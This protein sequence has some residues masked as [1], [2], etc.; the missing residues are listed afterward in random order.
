[1]KGILA[2]AALLLTASGAYAADAIVDVPPPVGEWTGFYA[3]L[4]IG[5]AFGS[6]P[7]GIELDPL[8]TT[9]GTA[10]S[11]GTN[12]GGLN[13][14]DAGFSGNF[15]NGVVG[16][17]HLGYDQQ[18]DNNVVLGGI[19][20]VNFT[21]IGDFQRGRSRT[22]A[23]YDFERELDVFATARL[24]AGYAFGR[25]LPYLTGGVAYGDVDSSYEDTSA[26]TIQG[27]SEENDKFGYSVGGGVEALVTDKVSIGLEYLYTDL[28]DNGVTTNLAG[29]NPANPFG[30]IGGAGTDR[31]GEDEDF[32]C[33]SV[34]VKFSYRF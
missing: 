24:R 34:Q 12:A 10:F 25:I 29:P 31:S 13:V 33:H 3:G 7:D 14:P 28:G 26:A 16:G 30:T 17:L 18:F 23:N 27:Q 8:T 9:L 1:M 6:D 19:I 21:D 4:Q 5:G 11:P 22:P 32:D 20:D 15:D 2:A